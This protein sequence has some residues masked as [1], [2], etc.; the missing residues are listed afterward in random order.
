MPDEPI[1]VPL[2]WL[3]L[4]LVT[5]T[6][7]IV[8]LVGYLIMQGHVGGAGRAT[9]A[10]LTPE[11]P[12]ANVT[13]LWQDDEL[14]KDAL[15]VVRARDSYRLL[16]CIFHPQCGHSRNFTK[17]LAE[18]AKQLQGEVT[19]LKIFPPSNSAALPRLFKAPIRGFPT[20]LL[21][22]RDKGKDVFE[23]VYT[24]DH[25]DLPFRSAESVVKFARA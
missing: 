2:S 23:M 15:E 1:C 25:N 22:T 3:V 13:V 8:G 5:S 10:P 4:T 14:T 17:P 16:V 19:V 24:P 9:V 7:I 11:A 21:E 6:A 18:A 12:T 20:L